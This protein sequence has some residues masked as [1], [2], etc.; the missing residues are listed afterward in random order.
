MGG[1]RGIFE[2]ADGKVG[3]ALSCRA[4]HDDKAQGRDAP[5]GI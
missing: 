2:T 3:K 1:N 5:G 4:Q